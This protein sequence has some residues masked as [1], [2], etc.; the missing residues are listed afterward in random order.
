MDIDTHRFAQGLDW[1]LLKTLHEIVKAGGVTRAGRA[2]SR[3][4]PAV[5]LALKR[6]E[7]SLGVRLCS[8]GR[9]GFSL[10]DEGA[11]VAE[12][13]DRISLLIDQLPN[14]LANVEQDVRGHVRLHMVSNIVCPRLDR[15]IARFH[16]LY[17]NVEIAIEV[18]AWETVASML[19]SG[20]ADIGVGPARFQRADLRYELLFEELHRLYCGRPHPL[21]RR[22]V[23]DPRRLADHPFI[24]TGADEFDALAKFRLE[25]G[26][27]RKLAGMSQHLEEAKRLAILGVGICFLPEG[28]AAPDVAAGRLSP[29]LGRSRM[30]SNE[31]FVITNPG[32]PRHLARQLF[33]K[34]IWRE[35]R[36]RGARRDA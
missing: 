25:F 20:A 26:I 32:A 22:R 9:G 7:R 35:T 34:E 6:L 14:R 2:M 33:L 13:C 31:V 29:L 23:T 18:A 28:Y 19:L 15:A 1:N 11:L 3:K 30:P 16:A 5:S 8:R 10:T 27:G 24:W 12:V 17:P 21:Y 36:G 4:Q